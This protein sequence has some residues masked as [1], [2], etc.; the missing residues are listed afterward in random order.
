MGLILISI[1][2]IN[3]KLSLYGLLLLLISHGLVS[4]LLFLLIGILYVRT[5]TRYIYY[6]KGLANILPLYSTI[7][8]IALLLNASLP[9]SLSYFA[10]LH[11]LLS[12]FHLEYIGILHLL[13]SLLFAGFYSLLL[14]TRISFSLYTS[15]T[16]LNDITL[17]EFYILIIPIIFS[18]SFSFIFPLNFLLTLT[19]NNKLYNIF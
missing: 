15:L 4:S 18:F 14:F 7:F 12:Q 17:T 6:Y 8:L 16:P 5:N 3:N 2:N 19:I 11:I 1:T 10:E 9:P 13:F